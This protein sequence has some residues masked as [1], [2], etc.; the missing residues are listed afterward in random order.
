MLSLLTV[1]S[2]STGLCI[3][4]W[5]VTVWI[6]HLILSICLLLSLFVFISIY[7]CML[8]LTLLVS[9]PWTISTLWILSPLEWSDAALAIGFS[10]WWKSLRVNRPQDKWQHKNMLP[11][12][13]SPCDDVIPG[14]FLNYYCTW[15]LFCHCTQ[16]KTEAQ[17]RKD[18]WPRPPAYKR[19]NQDQN[20]GPSPQ[21]VFT[22]GP[23][24]C[25]PETQPPCLHFWGL[26]TTPGLS[27]VGI[28]AAWS[29]LVCI[30]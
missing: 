14:Y 27:R 25:L 19:Q 13:Y 20:S 10:S 3:F 28:K 26:G 12:L 9:D 11:G 6:I 18:I 21:L 7:I 23:V 8:Q 4:L 2:G 5:H 16:E 29:S 15:H 17:P 24:F 30:R 22:D 1:H